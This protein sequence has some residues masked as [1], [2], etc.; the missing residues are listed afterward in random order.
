MWR[1][2]KNRSRDR[3]HR[4]HFLHP[5][6]LLF[7][8]VKT[9]ILW[10]IGRRKQDSVFT[11]PYKDKFL[12][13]A[14]FLYLYFLWRLGRTWCLYPFLRSTARSNRSLINKKEM[15]WRWDLEKENTSS[16]PLLVNVRRIQKR[17][18]A[19]ANVGTR[20]VS[21]AAKE[22]IFCRSQPEG[23]EEKW[24]ARTFPDSHSTIRCNR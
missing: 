24:A 8:G 6:H 18:T 20:V 10:R 1:W 5:L 3:I 13:P 16:I 22:R 21:K 9:R 23:R 4:Q 19:A 7:W 11:A 2:V 15:T 17:E 12:R 14:A